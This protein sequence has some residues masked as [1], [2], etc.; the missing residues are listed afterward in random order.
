MDARKYFLIVGDLEI[1]QFCENFDKT[2]LR[3]NVHK[4]K[5]RSKQS[6][7]VTFSNFSRTRS[8]AGVAIK[9]LHEQIAYKYVV[10]NCTYLTPD[11]LAFPA[12]VSRKRISSSNVCASAIKAAILIDKRNTTLEI[13]MQ[14]DFDQQAPSITT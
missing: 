10:H 11:T 12:E 8:K 6:Q 3:G 4:S 7:K 13:L 5:A 2:L 1:L 14:L 9:E